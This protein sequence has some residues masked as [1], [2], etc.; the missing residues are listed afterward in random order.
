MNA[1]TLARQV[2]TN[3]L[4]EK[5]RPGQLVFSDCDPLPTGRNIAKSTPQKSK[6]TFAGAGNLLPNAEVVVNLIIDCIDNPITLANFSTTAKPLQALLLAE[7]NGDYAAGIPGRFP[8][9]TAT[10]VGT[11]EVEIKGKPGKKFAISYSGF[12]VTI[13]GIARPPVPTTTLVESAYCSG[14][15]PF[16]YVVIKSKSTSDYPAPN[17]LVTGES[18]I[19]SLPIGAINSEVIGI[20]VREMAEKF[21]PFKNLNN[22]CDTTCEE[23]GVDCNDCYHLLKLCCTEQQAWIPLEA[24]PAGTV[25]PT[26]LEGIEIHY[27]NAVS[28]TNTKLG[29]PALKLTAAA[30]PTLKPLSNKAFHAVLVKLGGIYKGHQMARIKITP[31]SN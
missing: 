8:G 9:L 30:D 10:A 2:R 31:I 26:D 3:D 22:C 12:A 1:T 23:E 20:V 25:V 4:S 15:L 21:D 11:A 14:L 16:G 27:R 18:E 19:A 13:D 5:G 6:I 24:F 29:I 7:I 17:G 28:G